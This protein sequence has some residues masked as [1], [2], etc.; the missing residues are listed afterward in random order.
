ME[1]HVVN[2]KSN[3]DTLHLLTNNDFLK[4]RDTNFG[5]KK[6]GDDVEYM[7]MDLYIHKILLEKYT[8]NWK[9]LLPWEQKSGRLGGRSRDKRYGITFCVY[10]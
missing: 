7:C 3:G 6:V 4:A 5:F 1:Y 9:Y 8:R 2:K 10:L